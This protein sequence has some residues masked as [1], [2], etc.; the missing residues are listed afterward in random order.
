MHW[1]MNRI[2][3]Q[4]R[5]SPE[6]V[7]AVVVFVVVLLIAIISVI[8]SHIYLDEMNSEK[9]KASRDMHKW[10]SKINT[11]IENNQIIDE[12]EANFIRLV[13]QGVV[14]NEERLSWFETV[15]NTAG[16][17]GMPSVKYSVSSQEKLDYKNIQR[18][19]P[20]INVYKTTMTLNMKIGHEGDLFVLLNNLEKAN[21][22]YAV[23][24]CDIE[25]I[26]ITKAESLNN[27]K[28][29]C[30]L[31]WYTLRSAS[32]KTGKKGES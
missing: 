2:F 13:N 1:I 11:S 30:E 21:G 32:E 29:Y 16:K 3:K 12:F 19:F 28:A 26:N 22:L 14:G 31:G 23:D 10:Q 7:R 5:L 9:Q 6:L 4:T 17:R 27:M 8:G 20:G 25:K 24:R 18:E 15:Q